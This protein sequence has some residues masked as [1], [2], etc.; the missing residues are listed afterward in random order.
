MYPSNLNK[1]KI[2]TLFTF[3]EFPPSGRGSEAGCSKPRYEDENY[4]TNE[5]LKSVMPGYYLLCS[6]KKKI[7]FIVIMTSTIP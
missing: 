1:L 3:S 5:I 6:L 4:P 2:I 7:I